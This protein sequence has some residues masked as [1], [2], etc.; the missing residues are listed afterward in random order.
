MLANTRA[1]SS[2]AVTSQTRARVLPPA[3]ASSAARASTTLFMSASMT[4]AFA[5]G[6]I[7][8]APLMAALARRWPARSGLLAFV[9]VFAAAHAVS[10]LSANLP[11]LLVAR[12]VA[13]VANAGFLAVALTTA[14]T[15]VANDR[16]GRALAVLLSGTTVATIAG[17]PRG[18]ALGTLLGWR[19]TFW[20]IA[21]TCSW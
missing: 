19:A 3:S 17:V 13:A 12:V 20:A 8:G 1:M 5:A 15:L 11:V 9:L 7:I 10:A 21:M 14:A 16:K 4:S 2:S 6:M 18:A